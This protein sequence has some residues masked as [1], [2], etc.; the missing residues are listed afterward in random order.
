MEHLIANSGIHFIIKEIEINP[1]EPLRLSNGRTLKYSFCETTDFINGTK[2]F[3][4]LYYN[5]N[6]NNYLFFFPNKLNH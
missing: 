1:S 4:L 3:D 2:I 6:E 5:N